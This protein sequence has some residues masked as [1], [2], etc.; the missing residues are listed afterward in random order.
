[1]KTQ[2]AKIILKA[3]DELWAKV[4]SRAAMKQQSLNDTTIEL[5]K[6]GLEK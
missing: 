5:I 4:K 3:D 2:K 1:M 6:R